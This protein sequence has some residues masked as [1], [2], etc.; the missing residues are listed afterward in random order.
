[1]WSQSVCCGTAGF[2]RRTIAKVQGS[3]LKTRTAV[4][5]FSARKGPPNRALLETYFYVR[6]L[7][8]GLQGFSGAEMTYS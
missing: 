1:M 7:C 4:H 2:P 3:W 5:A 8:C 6:P